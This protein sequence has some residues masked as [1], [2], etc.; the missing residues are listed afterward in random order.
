MTMTSSCIA[1]IGAGLAGLAC[2]K[3]LSQAGKSVTV[4]EKA[5]GPG[6]RLSSRRRL[7]STFDIGAQQ[8]TA[9]QPAFAR[10]L[11]HWEKAGCLKPWQGSDTSPAWVGSPRM[12]ALTRHFSQGL[13]LVTGTRI[14]H[15]QITTDKQWL[16][17]DATGKTWGPFSQVVLATPASQALPLIDRV[18][19]TLKQQLQSVKEEP[20]WVAYF[21]LHSTTPP[22]APCHQPASSYL[23]RAT[24]LNSKPDQASALERWVIEATPQWSQQHLELSKEEVARRLFSIWANDIALEVPSCPQLLEAHRWLYGLASSHRHEGFLEDREQQILV[25]GDFCYGSTAEA[26]WMSGQQSGQ[27][28]LKTIQ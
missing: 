19:P 13:H 22:L 20:I 11:D 8:L 7:G 17:R 25:C 27:A 2:A 18:S 23:R 12:S 3:E 28:L 4:F 5:R 6:G 10:Q 16:L 14:T 26:A 9:S 21:A 24:L 1:V 15:L